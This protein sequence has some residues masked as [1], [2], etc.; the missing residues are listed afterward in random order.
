ML[1]GRYFSVDVWDGSDG[2]PII[3]HGHTL[4]VPI[5][6]RD[7]VRVIAEYA[8]LTSPYPVI[9]SI[10]NHCSLSQQKVMAQCFKSTFGSKLYTQRLNRNENFLPS[11]EALKEKFLI[12]VSVL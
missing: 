6:L 12:K 3:N 1:F 10:E 5:L 11:P 8:F 4:V 9:L 2:E 7:A